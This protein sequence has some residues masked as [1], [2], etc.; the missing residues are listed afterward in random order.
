[1]RSTMRPRQDRSGLRIHTGNTDDDKVHPTNF[2]ADHT[3]QWKG[4]SA[5]TYVELALKGA[6]THEQMRTAFETGKLTARQFKRAFWQ[7]FDPG[8]SLTAE[9]IGI[10]RRFSPALV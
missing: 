4:A 1:M 3:T 6:L 2:G 7:L 10:I 5:R 8:V 9:T